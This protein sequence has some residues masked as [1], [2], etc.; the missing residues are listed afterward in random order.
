MADLAE[1]VA[2]GYTLPSQWY[3][4]PEI[5]REEQRKILRRSWHFVPAEI[6]GVPIVLVRG[7]D[8]ES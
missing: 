1:S 6:G 8:G 3:A 2:A 5:F 4:D 7:D